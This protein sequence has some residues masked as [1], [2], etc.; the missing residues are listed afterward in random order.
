MFEYGK[1]VFGYGRRGLFSFF[2]KPI[3]LS[4]PPE[5]GVDKYL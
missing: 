5:G 2:N 4:K 1:S 3:V